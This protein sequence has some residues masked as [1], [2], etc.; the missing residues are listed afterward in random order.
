MVEKRPRSIAVFVDESGSMRKLNYWKRSRLQDALDFLERNE[1][2]N[3]QGIRFRFHR[4][5]D[6]VRGNGATPG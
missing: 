4:F 1:L 6:S 5:S 3:R 2:R